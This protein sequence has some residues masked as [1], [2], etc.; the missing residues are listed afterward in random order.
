MSFCHL[1]DEH[2]CVLYMCSPTPPPISLSVSWTSCSVAL[3]ETKLS[4][5]TD[6]QSVLHP[7]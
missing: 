4:R 3:K 6:H 1:L 2:I 7:A 5:S